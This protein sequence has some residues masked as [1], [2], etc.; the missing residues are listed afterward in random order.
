MVHRPMVKREKRLRITL[1]LNMVTVLF[2]LFLGYIELIVVFV[3]VMRGIT[4][5]KWDQWICCLYWLA[6]LSAVWL[7]SF[8]VALLVCKK[9]LIIEGQILRIVKGGETLY[10]CPVS[11][12]RAVRRLRFAPIT[13]SFPGGIDILNNLH[14]IPKNISL[15]MSWISYKRI[16]TFI[17]KTKCINH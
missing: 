7:V 4:T 9:Q 17:K 2:P 13:Q 5:N 14:P 16:C 15:C 8:L 11:E 10:Q 1:S 12:I 3:Q 6:G